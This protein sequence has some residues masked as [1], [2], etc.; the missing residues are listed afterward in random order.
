MKHRVRMYDSVVVAAPVDVTRMDT[1]DKVKLIDSYVSGVKQLNVTVAATHAGRLTRNRGFYLPTRMKKGANTMLSREDGGTSPYPKP[2]L[3]NHNRFEQNDPIGRIRSAEYVDI[4]SSINPQL[5]P[6]IK[7]FH[8]NR[9][10][11][12]FVDL[13][14]TLMES[15]LIYDKQFKGMGFIRSMADITDP[16]AIV[17]VL[18]KRY[19]TVSTSADTDR[20]VCS[21]CREDWAD[22]GEPCEHTP[23]KWYD[24]KMCFLI[25]GDLFYEEWSFVTKT[26]DEEAIVLSILGTDSNGGIYT[27]NRSD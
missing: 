19:M 10:F 15:K 4:S 17:K 1:G 14:E 13:V 11:Y 16:D 5:M 21:I 18:D 26:A 2:V 6:V 20:A 27:A 8:I 3:L 7:D 24:N 9:P 25:A 23:G 12:Q 22:M